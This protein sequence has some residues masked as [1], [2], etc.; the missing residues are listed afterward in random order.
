MNAHVKQLVSTR[1]RKEEFTINGLYEPLLSTTLVNA[2][3]QLGDKTDAL[4]LI[5]FKLNVFSL[6]NTDDRMT[7]S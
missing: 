7:D 6:M 5:Y 3:T 4:K 2:C 1:N